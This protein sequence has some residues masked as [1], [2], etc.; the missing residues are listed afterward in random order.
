MSRL[1]YDARWR[2][3]AIQAGLM[4]GAVLAVL[5]VAHNTVSNLTARGIRVGFDFLAR[6]ARFPISESVLPFTPDD[7]FGWAYVVGLANTI[8]I[9]FLAIVFATLIGFVVAL[10][11]RSTHPLLSAVAQGW[12]TLLRNV[13]L[14]VQLLFWY[15]VT[16]T[17]L[18]PPRAAFQ[19]LPGLFLSQ[20]GIYFPT[21]PALPLLIAAA[22]GLAVGL[23]AARLLHRRGRRLVAA[24]LGLA[25]GGVVLA[26]SGATPSVP[27]LEGFNF[28]G[29][30]VLSPEFA[31]LMIG[32]VL[33]TAAFIG[34]IIR[35]GIDAIGRGQWEAGRA[36]G[37]ADR[38]VLRHIIMPQALRVILPPLGSQYLSTVKNTTLALAVGF[39]DLGLVVATVVNQTGQALE[40]LALMIAIYLSISVSVSLLIN[41]Y[42]ARVAIVTR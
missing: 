15:A 38:Q 37:I 13:P 10:A 33:Y 2:G 5:W 20:R 41:W 25:A 24:S 3:W 14:I 12:V 26:A 17:S 8:W 1:W 6:P 4:A 31:A 19:P 18:P 22:A 32:L 40:N 30:G 39:P 7:T 16:T 28:R 9:S 23:G 34:E 36:L 21:L 29:G 35:G 42:N 11:R 27:H